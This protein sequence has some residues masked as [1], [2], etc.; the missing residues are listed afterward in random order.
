VQERRC[1]EASQGKPH[2]SLAVTVR[3]VQGLTK[4]KGQLLEKVHVRT[5]EELANLKYIHWA[6][7]ICTLAEYEEDLSR[8]E[9]KAA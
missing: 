4:E 6:E 1:I 5:V 2:C 3:C 8:K 7:A 9:A